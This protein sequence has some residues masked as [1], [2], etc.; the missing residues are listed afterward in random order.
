MQP[1]SILKIAALV[2]AVIISLVV[3]GGSYFTVPEGYIGVKT[4]FKATTA[5]TYTAG[6]HFKLPVI[7][8]VRFINVQQQT[9]QKTQLDAVTM[10]PDLQ[11]VTTDIAVN[12]SVDPSRATWVYSNFRDTDTL[13]LNSL[14]PAL[15]ESVKSVTAQYTA[16]QLISKRQD[17]RTG[18]V[19]TL[20]AKLSPSLT[21]P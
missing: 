12:F 17:V 5:D 15:E 10:P 9:F 2:I 11:R 18:L 3:F 6:L 4:R 16:E 14:A 13:V 8:D 7:E 19:S 21:C 20:K 1:K